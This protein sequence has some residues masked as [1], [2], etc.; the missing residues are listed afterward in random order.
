[1]EILENIATL[2][3][4]NVETLSYGYFGI[5][6]NGNIRNVGTLSHGNI[7]ILNDGNIETLIRGN[8]GIIGTTSHGNIG[9]LSKGDIIC[10]STTKPTISRVRP[11][12]AQ[13]DQSLCR[14]YVPS[15]AS[16][17]SKMG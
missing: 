14:S 2:S 15:T 7:G 1:M 10:A 9:T 13:S 5:Q 12:S 6:T 3:H 8:I 11:A 17:L 4:G 16:G